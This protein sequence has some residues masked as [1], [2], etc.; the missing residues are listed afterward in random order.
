MLARQFQGTF[1]GVL[2]D[3]LAALA[4]LG[5]FALGQLGVLVVLVPPAFLVTWAR[6]PRYALL[7]GV[8]TAVTCLFAAS[9]L[10]AQ[11]ERYYL[12][13][14]LFAWSWLAIGAATI[15]ERVLDRARR[16]AG[17]RSRA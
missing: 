12:G 9:Y 11:I 2:A 15:V 3:P 6:F 16:P 13:P 1:A 10:N 8:A 5:R 7:S 4:G 14:A 17:D